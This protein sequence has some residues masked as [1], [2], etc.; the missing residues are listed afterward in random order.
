MKNI[1][2]VVLCACF[3]ML[4]LPGYSNTDISV[5]NKDVQAHI[6][7]LMQQ[8][9]Q[10]AAKLDKLNKQYD[11]INK[12]L[13]DARSALRAGTQVTDIYNKDG[14]DKETAALIDRC[15]QAEENYIKLKAELEKK[16]AELPA[17][18]E[19]KA[20]YEEARATFDEL[21]Q[22]KLK[23][24]KERNSV[25]QDFRSIIKEIEQEKSK[26]NANSE[27]VDG[28]SGASKN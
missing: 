7:E 27:D 4:S 12:K 2:I 22:K 26:L 3:L 8:K 17:G 18:K 24:I 9:A 28:V 13:F 14:I 11:D 25:A 10:I 19:R 23:I 1:N 16:L 6:S 20:K 15:K 21:K 5:D